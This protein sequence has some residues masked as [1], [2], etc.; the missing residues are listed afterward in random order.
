ML[1]ISVRTLDTKARVV[2]EDNGSGIDVN[3]LAVLQAMSINH[4][5]DGRSGD[6]RGV[7]IRNTLARMRVCYG[8]GASVQIQSRAGAGTRVTLDIPPIV[9]EN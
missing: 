5:S 3:T 6:I 4:Q 7:G 9:V 2:I 8:S 1:T